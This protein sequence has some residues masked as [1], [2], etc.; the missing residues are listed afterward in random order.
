MTSINLPMNS[1]KSKSNDLVKENSA[2]MTEDNGVPVNEPSALLRQFGFINP[3]KINRPGFA[4][5]PA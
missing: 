2:L 5:W 3:G 1:Q 4:T